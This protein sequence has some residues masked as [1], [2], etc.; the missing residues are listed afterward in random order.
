MP[1]LIQ[2]FTL[3]IAVRSKHVARAQAIYQIERT[4]TV[5]NSPVALAIRDKL[6]EQN[7]SFSKVQTIHSPLSL[8][9]YTMLHNVPF[10]GQLYAFRAEHPQALL[11]AYQNGMSTNGLNFQLTFH[12]I[13]EIEP[14]QSSTRLDK[15]QKY[16]NSN[17]YLLKPVLTSAFSAL[18]WAAMGAVFALDTPSVPRSL[19][20][21]VVLVTGCTY[22]FFLVY[23]L[24]RRIE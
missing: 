21:L 18:F 20:L 15:L 19:Y 17:T 9:S 4:Q 12:C 16:Y 7:I 24:S 23:S 2:T 14:G 8:G 10:D 13:R 11:D 6:I 3:N 1:P 22:I 5:S